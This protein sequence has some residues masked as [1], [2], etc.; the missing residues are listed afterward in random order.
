[1][2]CMDKIYILHKTLLLSECESMDGRESLTMTYVRIWVSKINQLD[3]FNDVNSLI[4]LIPRELTIA[5]EGYDYWD[6]SPSYE[7]SERYRFY[8]RD[9]KNNCKTIAVDIDIDE[10]GN[11]FPSDPYYA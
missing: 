6:S 8:F 3:K 5:Y 9:P 1:M 10:H 7:D 2:F 11:I 4:W